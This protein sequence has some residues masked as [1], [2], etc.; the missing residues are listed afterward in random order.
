MEVIIRS[1]STGLA[2]FVLLVFV[3]TLRC[4]FFVFVIAAFAAVASPLP[5]GYYVRADAVHVKH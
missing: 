1:K 3:D 4:C 2:I 5:S